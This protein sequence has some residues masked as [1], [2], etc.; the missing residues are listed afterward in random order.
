[1]SEREWD[2]RTSLSLKRL[3]LGVVACL[4][5]LW[6]QYLAVSNI[7]LGPWWSDTRS[8]GET[9]SRWP[10]EGR[11]A[12]AIRRAGYVILLPLG[13][14]VRKGFQEQS[15]SGAWASIAR[16]V[17]PYQDPRRNHVRFAVLNTLAW[18]LCGGI[19]WV[20]RS[21]LAKGRKAREGHV[22][23]SGARWLV[24]IGVSLWLALLAFDVGP[25]YVPFVVRAVLGGVALMFLICTAR[26]LIVMRRAGSDL[27]PKLGVSVW[28]PL[29]VF[30]GVLISL[31]VW[32]STTFPRL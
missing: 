11:A 22:S 14:L 17:E 1:M 19:L 32:V 4:L 5:C 30:G 27:R 10:L 2:A 3:A 23:Q 25:R 8:Y 13:P 6:L 7:P 18:G 12:T 26:A 29:I 24:G 21:H 20:A 31:L 9:F 28:L 15:G 16:F